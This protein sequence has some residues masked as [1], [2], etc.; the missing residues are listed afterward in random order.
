MHPVS[1]IITKPAAEQ[2]GHLACS[3]TSLVIL[4]TQQGTDSSP[5]GNSH[6]PE[7]QTKPGRFFLP[8][9]DKS[10]T[11]WLKHNALLLSIL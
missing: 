1:A 4:R 9:Q 10:L 7:V 6:I 2:L 5:P 8:A 3:V 11:T